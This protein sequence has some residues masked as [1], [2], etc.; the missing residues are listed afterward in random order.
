M[1]V[2]SIEF[3]ATVLAGAMVFFH[4]RS[5]TWRQAAYACGNLFVLWLLLPNWSSAAVLALFLGSG[6]AVA[7]QLAVRPS[8]ILLAGY[9]V[10]LVACYAMLKQYDVLK[11]LLPDSLMSQHVVRIV[12]L[13]YM[14]FR[15]IHFLVDAAQ[16]QAGEITI[17]N[18][19][20]Y[21]LNVFAILSGPIQRYQDF[22][23][24]WNVLEP[25][26]PDR[27][28][29]LNTC[30]R[31][32]FGV[33]KVA[34][35]APV[36]L[37]GWQE[38]S[39]M[40]IGGQVGGWRYLCKFVAVFYFYPLYLYFNFSGYCDIVIAANRFFGIRL[41]ENFDRPYVARNVLDFWNRWHITLGQW[42]RD[43]LFLPMYKPIVE[44]WPKR[45]PSLA[46]LCLFVA[47]LVAGVWHGST[48]N[49]LV[50][51]LCQGVGAS[52]AKL[53][54]NHLLK[55]GGRQRLKA[56]LASEPIRW[57]AIFCHLHFQAF[58]LMFFPL[59]LAGTMHI[60]KNVVQVLTGAL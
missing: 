36:F 58:A 26:I 9:L 33:F 60:L 41:P 18:Y 47:F 14:L 19:L 34:L 25:V 28:E 5:L 38:L 55:R 30:F 48:T 2:C 44:H 49:F 8:R 15:Q 32:L 59:S 56:Y 51:G 45:A 52:A 57:T 21:Q 6:Y 4:V 39:P 43:Y 3:I 35:I 42:I 22:C 10:L 31:I 17:W 37:R 7:R 16:G 20:N 12:G 50:Y 24:Q 23:E 29:L 40:V 54:E 46:F 13:S 27:Q 1:N 53:W 11:Y